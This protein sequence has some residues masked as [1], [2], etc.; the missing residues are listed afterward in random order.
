ME[1]D[2]SLLD[3]V[4]ERLAAGEVRLPVFN[5]VAAELTRLTSRDDFEVEEVTR[6]IARD[7][8]VASQLLRVANSSFFA[9]LKKVATVREAIVRLGARKVSSLVA[10]VTQ[11]GSYHSR[12]PVIAAH[13]QT[14]WRH[15][16]GTALGGEWLAGK[17][18]YRALAGEA[19]LAGLLHDIGELVL[20]KVLE[21]LSL[22]RELEL[23]LAP[24]VI[25]DVLQQLHAEQGARL[26]EGWNLPEPYVEVARHHH[27]PGVDAGN[28][29]LVLVRLADAACRKLGEDLAG[30]PTL[31]LSA[32]PEADALAAKD[33]AQ[34]PQFRH[35]DPLFSMT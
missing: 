18:G 6:L 26:L 23:N 28:T 33:L 5:P 12:H 34:L 22:R 7:Q 20:L 27:A 14:L 31:V 15:A 8:S 11:K 25:L 1:N 2:R 10:L 35:C 19:L 29:L 32:L 17:L 3:L 30:E 21:E 16:V 4:Q 24:E 13:L 9:G